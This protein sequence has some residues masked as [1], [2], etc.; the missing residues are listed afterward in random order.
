MVRHR[1]LGPA[2]SGAEG[3]A[4]EPQRQNDRERDHEAGQ[5]EHHERG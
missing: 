3:H 5:A 2:P 4:A 1:C